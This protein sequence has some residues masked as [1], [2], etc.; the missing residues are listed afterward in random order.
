MF[1]LKS[2]NRKE[3]VNVY[4]PV[5]TC[6]RPD[7]VKGKLFM[8]P[9]NSLLKRSRAG[10]SHN[11]PH[12]GSE[13]PAKRRLGHV[14]RETSVP[15]SSWKKISSLVILYKEVW[16][17][18]F[19]RKSDLSQRVEM[20][21]SEQY[22]ESREALP[23]ALGPALCSQRVFS[24]QLSAPWLGPSIL[25]LNTWRT[26]ICLLPVPGPSPWDQ[27]GDFH[28]GDA[29]EYTHTRTAHKQLSVCF[30]WESFDLLKEPLLWKPNEKIIEWNLF[31]FHP[32]LTL[33]PVRSEPCRPPFSSG[34][35]KFDKNTKGPF[36]SLCQ[37]QLD[38]LPCIQS[39]AVTSLSVFHT[40]YVSG[41]FL[42]HTD[43]QMTL[44]Q[45][46]HGLLHWFIHHSEYA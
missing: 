43:N 26:P 15:L 38:K 19:T 45:S 40:N 30:H 7:L 25:L 37:L 9:L 3:S 14:R 33:V 44:Q 35:C 8:L 1:A 12:N 11:K 5:F 29:T 6:L 13:R 22:T 4:G 28:A 23:A 17:P 36:S 24:W 27:R 21:H 41:P 46:Q 32:F 16:R 34:S 2:R 10:N 39:G 20:A 42:M 31:A 18:H